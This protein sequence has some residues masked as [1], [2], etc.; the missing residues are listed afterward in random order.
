MHLEL[1]YKQKTFYVNN[2]KNSK[3]WKFRIDKI[4]F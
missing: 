2:S 4:N 1:E 3:K